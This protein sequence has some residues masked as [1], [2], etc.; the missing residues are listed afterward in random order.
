MTDIIVGSRRSGKSTELIK[1]SAEENI[2]ILTG[3]K[4]QAQCL[5][6]QARELGYNIPFPVTWEDYTRGRLLGTKIQEDG[7]LIDEASHV[8]SQAL[9]G[10]PIKSVTWSKYGFRDLD[11]EEPER[12]LELLYECYKRTGDVNDYKD[13]RDAW[14]VYK[15]YLIEMYNIPQW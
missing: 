6:N 15:N 5:F 8:L 2:Y 4:S 14:E 12:Y 3:N 11:Q 1:M 7:V 9:K 13:W 10:I